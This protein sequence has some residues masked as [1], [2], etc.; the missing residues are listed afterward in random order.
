MSPPICAS[1]ITFL[2]YIQTVLILRNFPYSCFMWVLKG[3]FY[4]VDLFQDLSLLGD[5]TFQCG[6]AWTVAATRFEIYDI[7][8]LHCLSGPRL[9]IKTVLSTYG[10]FHVKD[11]TAVRRLIFNMGIA[12]PGKTVFLIETAPWFFLP[13]YILNHFS[14]NI[15]IQSVNEINIPVKNMKHIIEW[16]HLTHAPLSVIGFMGWKEMKWDEIIRLNESVCQYTYICI[17]HTY[18]YTFHI[19][20]FYHNKYIA[21]TIKQ[22]QLEYSFK[23]ILSSLAEN[24]SRYWG[25]DTE[26][27]PSIVKL[28]TCTSS[29]GNKYKNFS[30]V[31]NVENMGLLPDIL[32]SSTRLSS[33]YNTQSIMKRLSSSFILH[34]KYDLLFKWVL[35]LC[36]R[37]IQFREDQNSI[38]FC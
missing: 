36:V 5:T 37:R 7:D 16:L 13:M 8:W 11:K 30:C 4:Y 24:V 3:S 12:I 14:S 35:D 21:F 31:D 27:Y 26:I 19:Y 15:K 6:I 25:A 2:I 23:R 1:Y 34:I 18:I 9:N 20:V 28:C 33:L 10:D 17:Y 32:S 22:L 29:H 38:E